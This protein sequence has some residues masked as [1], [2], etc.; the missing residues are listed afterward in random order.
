MLCHL[1]ERFSCSDRSRH[2]GRRNFRDE[3]KERFALNGRVLTSQKTHADKVGVLLATDHREKRWTARRW[4]VRH[5]D[6]WQH[7]MRNTNG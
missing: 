2:V 5:H 1:T 3:V 4:R 7:S 6:F